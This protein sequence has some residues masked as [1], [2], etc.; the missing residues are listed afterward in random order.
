MLETHHLSRRFHAC[1]V[2]HRTSLRRH[3]DAPA[4]LSLNGP[5][6]ATK[7]RPLEPVAGSIA[8]LTCRNES[9]RSAAHAENDL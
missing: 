7:R 2:L 9:M 6:T 3:E 5:D 8:G 1:Q 4:R